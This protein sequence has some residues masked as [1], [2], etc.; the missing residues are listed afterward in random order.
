MTHL[1][2]EPFCGMSYVLKN[3]ARKVHFQNGFVYRTRVRGEKRGGRFRVRPDGEADVNNHNPVQEGIKFFAGE[4]V[5]ASSL[6][7]RRRKADPATGL[8][9]EVLRL[10]V[11]VPAV[12]EDLSHAADVALAIVSGGV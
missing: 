8:G 4:P 10:V 7:T 5:D 1:V 6:A 9:E 2:V 3:I 11:G 12:A